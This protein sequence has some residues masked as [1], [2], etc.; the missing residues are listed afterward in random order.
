MADIS[1]SRAAEAD[2]RENAGAGV[3]RRCTFAD[4]ADLETDPDP[5]AGYIFSVN[6]FPR[7]AAA[8]QITQVSNPYGTLSVAGNVLEFSFLATAEL[9]G[10]RWEL[11]SER[12]SDG[13]KNK[14]IV[15][16]LIILS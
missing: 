15:G 16:K 11:V 5:L 12:I 6:L 14:L 3:W 1:D 4:L 7:A 13:F 2:I 9:N 10:A 8:Y